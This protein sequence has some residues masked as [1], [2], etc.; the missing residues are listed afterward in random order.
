MIH[1][2]LGYFHTSAATAALVFGAFIFPMMKGSNLHKVLGY[3]YASA[4]L[5]TNVTAFGL[6][7][8]TGHF[9]LFHVA[10]I[11][12]FL[13][14]VAALIPVV[15]RRPKKSWLSLH[16]KYTSW[17][18]IGLSAAALSEAAVRLP[19]APFWPAVAFG[20]AIFFGIGGWLITRMK[21][22][23]LARAWRI[24]HKSLAG[25]PL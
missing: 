16:Y 1:S 5:A 9:G 20:S 23:T 21:E 13:T 24:S 12:S 4:L 22:R 18:Y 10:A 25:S 2:W 3:L 6:Y 7:H 19:R 11:V 8:L 17:S 15:T 14:L